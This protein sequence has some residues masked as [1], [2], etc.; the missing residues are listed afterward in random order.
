MINSLL[1]LLLSFSF[2]TANLSE[3]PF[4]YEIQGGL[5]GKT[6]KIS[7]MFE[8][9]NGTDYYGNDIKLS[10]KYFEFTN[11]IK[12]AKQINN[13]GFSFLY[14]KQKNLLIGC[15]YNLKK[16]EDP[17]VLFTI[18]YQ[19][20]FFNVRYFRGYNRENIDLDLKGKIDLN[21]RVKLIP[22]FMIKK[23]DDDI[24]WQFKVGLEIK[25]RRKKKDK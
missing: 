3:K 9:E 22:L 12:T 24:F 18:A 4:D 8:R 21:N 19:K 14:P 7:Y 16:W 23:Y 17:A 6:N 10:I 20:K 5:A 1:I 25:L 11:Y 15:T 13:Q 2:R